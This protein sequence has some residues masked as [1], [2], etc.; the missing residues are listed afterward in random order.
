MGRHEHLRRQ[1]ISRRC[2]PGRPGQPVCLPGTTVDQRQQQL[3]HLRVSCGRGRPVAGRRVGAVPRG[4][5]LARR[6][7]RDAHRPGGRRRPAALSRHALPVASPHGPPARPHAGVRF[8]DARGGRQELGRALFF[9]PRL[10]ASGRVACGTCHKPEHGW[11]ESREV[12]IPHG[13]VPG[14]NTPTVRNAAFQA[15]LFWDGRAASLEAQAAEALADPHEMAATPAHVI[16]T[17]ANTPAHRD[18]YAEAFPGRPLE[19]TAVAEAIACFERTL[20]GGRSRFDAFLRGDS[21]ALTDPELLGLD[22]FRREGR[23][24][25]CHHGPTLS[26]GRFHDLGLSFHGR[27]NEDLGRHGVTRDPADK[28]RFRT[29]S[30]RDVTNT[31]PFMHTGM[32]QLRGVLNMY[33]AGMATLKRQP[34]ERDDPT[35]PVKS[36]LLKPLGLNRQDLADLEAFLGALAE[37]A[38]SGPRPWDSPGRE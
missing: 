22:L 21:T 38:T 4:I 3:R 1:G 27:S 35:F 13:A 23:C 25:N 24:L 7:R 34:F 36:P 28:G 19:F 14:R 9:D 30:L 16:D 5:R 26:D 32:F 17:I 37:P 8:R 31:P 18:R 33:N 10:S 6:G 12:S 20:V 11:A 15:A 2:V 29:P